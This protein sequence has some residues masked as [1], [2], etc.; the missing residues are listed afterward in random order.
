M[1]KRG[2]TQRGAGGVVFAPVRWVFKL[3]FW[4]FCAVVLLQLWYLAQ[5]TY[6]ARFNPSSTSFMNIRLE[7]MR[8]TDRSAQLKHEWVPYDQISMNLKRAVVAAEDSGFMNH[9]GVEPEAIEVAIQKNQ[10][11][12][13]VTHGGST[14]TQQLAKNLFLTSK[15]SYIRKGQELVIAFMLEAIWG[16]RR[17]LEVYLNV[18]EWGNGVYGAQAASRYYYGVNASQLNAAQ[19]SRL[20]SMLPAP[21]YFDKRRG[22]PFLARKT[23]TVQA[24]LYQVAV[25]K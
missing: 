25:P 19:A 22:S 1:V 4:A 10:R 24:R 16:K 13:K 11:R 2:N 23:A 18:V 15:R 8:K 17:I 9:Y 20:A 3:L 5:I 21:R 12:G 6:W 7:E 14:I